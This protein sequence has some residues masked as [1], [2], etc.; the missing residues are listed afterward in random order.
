MYTERVAAGF[1]SPADDY[2]EDKIDLNQYL[3]KHPASTFLVRASGNSM[4]N[5]GIFPNDI[6]VVDKSIKAENGNVVIA[7]IDG[8]LTVKRYLT[9]RSSI[10]LQPENE[11]YEPIA[12]TGKSEAQICGRVTSVITVV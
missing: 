6:L 2:L 9:K 4:I 11:D 5:A 12:L 8:E 3:V 10:V 1:P 7:I